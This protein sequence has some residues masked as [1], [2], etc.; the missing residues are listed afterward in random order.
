MN[1]ENEYLDFDAAVSFLNTT[2]STMYKWL[3]AGKIPG[4]KLGRQW[5]FLKEELEIHVSGKGSKINVQK[6][7]LTVA[8]VLQDRSINKEKKMETT[9]MNKLPEQILW[10]AFDH[11]SRLVHMYPSKGK[12]EISYRTNAG[13]EKLCS[14]QEESFNE[15]DSSLN[16]L[17]TSTYDGTARRFYLHR[18]DEEVLQVKYHKI[19]TV[20]GPRITLRLWQT[21][22]D[23]LPLNKITGDEQILENFKSWTKKKH[24][25]IIVSGVSGSGKSTTVFSLLNE[26]KNQGRV[27]F[28][29]EESV[30]FVMD[31]INQIEMK[32]TAKGQ[33]DETF[34]KVY[35][36]DPDVIC[37]GLG[38]NF[39]YEEKAFAAA[40]RAASTG[41]LVIVQM[42]QP[43]CE[44]ALEFFKTHSSLPVENVLVGISCQK[45]VAEGGRIKAK[46]EFMNKP[47]EM[48]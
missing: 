8:Q 27:I 23:I 3:Q 41:H 6:D 33:F 1:V 18:S 42:D 39:G 36:S 21:E 34:E 30:D 22:K 31:G 43:S 37:L 7:F 44:K 5:R 13:L 45:L 16:K 25:L 20:S 26:F 10:D 14:I 47:V 38:L 11:G 12:F 32:E 17:S 35:S 15:I 28:T 9:S 40:Y 19:E 48:D 46:Y 24:G 4:H 2:P 29:I